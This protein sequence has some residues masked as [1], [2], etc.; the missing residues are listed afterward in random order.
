VNIGRL[1]FHFSAFLKTPLMGGMGVH[2]FNFAENVVWEICF[3]ICGRRLIFT[4]EDT[5]FARRAAREMD[6]LNWIAPRVALSESGNPGLTAATTFGV[7]SRRSVRDLLL[8]YPVDA[9][10]D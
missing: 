7:V 1:V 3:G 8:G 4:E 5:R 6:G 2:A 10:G 9:V